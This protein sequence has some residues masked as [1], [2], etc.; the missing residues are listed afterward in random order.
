[1]S[2][3]RLELAAP[4]RRPVRLVWSGVLAVLGL[5]MAVSPALAVVTPLR[6]DAQPSTHARTASAPVAAFLAAPAASAAASPGAG[7]SPS[8]DPSASP[9]P[10]PSASP[11][12]S[13]SASPDP[14]P[15]ASPTPDPTPAWSKTVTTVGSSIRFYGRGNGHG[16]GMSQWGARGRA[17]AGQTAPEILSA[18]FRGSTVGTLT[19]SRYVRVLVLSGFAGAATSPLTIHGRSGAWSMSGVTGT[20]PANAALTVWRT[21]AVVSGVK[22]V[23]WHLHV[24]SADGKTVLYDGKAASSTVTIKTAETASRLQLNSKPSTYDTYRGRLVLTLKSTSVSVVNW[25]QLEDYLKGVVPVEMPASWPVEALNAQAIV[26]RSWTL[27]HFRSTTTYTYDVYDDSRSQ[28]YRGVKAE[29]AGVN[30]LLAAQPGATLYYGTGVVNA[31][32]CAA[33]GGWTENNED[34]FVGANGVISSSPLPYLR[35]RDDRSATGAAFDAGAPGFAWSTA[36][37]T[38]AQLNAILAA[39]SRTSVGTVTKLDLTHRGASGRLDLVVINGSTGKKTVS[40]DVFRAVFNAHRPA[41]TA[42]ML[43]NLFDASPLP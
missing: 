8:P 33:A 35:G 41:G 18:Y 9:S 29:N 26:A 32:Y 17:T 39:D 36:S 13:P 27:K 7:A 4:A 12:P 40:G 10:D 6:A 42:S 3:A 19:T 28:V 25:V 1:M 14:T 43:S 30:A 37:I 2:I 16:V 31:F 20:F 15:T 38:H 11:D 22:V 24:V 34:A 23:T 5:A 21:S